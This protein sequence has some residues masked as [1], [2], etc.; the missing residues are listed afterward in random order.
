MSKFSNGG[1]LI[2]FPLLFNFLLWDKLPSIYSV[3]S[4]NRN[5]PS[6]L[7][8]CENIL[9]IILFG[10]PFFFTFSFEQKSQKVGFMLYLLG[11]VLYFS[12]WFIQIC[13][14]ESIWSHSMA[15][16]T[17]PAFLPLI[18]LTGIALMI[19]N[20]YWSSI[21]YK[22]LYYIVISMLFSIVHITHSV[23]AYAKR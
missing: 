10:L 15:G 13:Q 6:I 22:P 14:P 8:I 9:R 20:S 18:W 2:L 16:F 4:F 21:P 12:S 19:K 23:M 11:I 17:A 7:L 5:I 3:E 1:L